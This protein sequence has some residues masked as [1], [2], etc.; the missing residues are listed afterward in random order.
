[1]YPSNH[2]YDWW[3][4]QKAFTLGSQDSPSYGWP[5]PRILL[6][7]S[8]L[9][10]VWEW[11]Y[12]ARGKNYMSYWEPVL[13]LAVYLEHGWTRTWFLCQGLLLKLAAWL[14]LGKFLWLHGPHFSY[15][16]KEWETLPCSPWCSL[17]V[18]PGD[19][20]EDYMWTTDAVTVTLPLTDNWGCPSQQPWQ[21]LL[22][23]SHLTFS[24]SSEWERKSD[25]GLW[26][27]QAE[28]L[29]ELCLLYPSFPGH[30]LQGTYSQGQQV[31][32]SGRLHIS[33]LSWGKLVLP[34]ILH[35]WS[36]WA[37]SGSLISTQKPPFHMI[38]DPNFL[39]SFWIS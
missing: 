23:N 12:E 28:V 24:V 33:C 11:R 3:T 14:S 38:P 39:I 21:R 1:M 7:S 37:G 10:S 32:F 18:L 17:E 4:A 29:P 19:L 36:Y 22:L 35:H 30:T 25:G 31:P 27:G 26:T 9:T 16:E 6:W 2:C 20:R 13:W 34:L 8:C 15:M 5:S